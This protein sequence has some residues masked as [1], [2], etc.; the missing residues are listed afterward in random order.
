MDWLKAGTCMSLSSPK[1]WRTD[2]VMS[3]PSSDSSA[4]PWA[5]SCDMGLRSVKDAI[6]MDAIVMSVGYYLIRRV[7]QS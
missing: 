2:T 5:Y 4:P 3:G 6:V 1:V 7:K